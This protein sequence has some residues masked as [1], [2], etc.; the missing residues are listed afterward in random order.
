[1]KA[2]KLIEV[3]HRSKTV[4]N[5]TKILDKKISLM[6]KSIHRS[7]DREEEANGC[8]AHS[9][10]IIRNLLKVV[11]AEYFLVNYSLGASEKNK[12]TVLLLKLISSF[13][14]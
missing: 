5:K 14:Y 7:I 1:M 6:F 3:R 9:K 2:N 11:H 8:I 4:G 13:L 12:R 10:L